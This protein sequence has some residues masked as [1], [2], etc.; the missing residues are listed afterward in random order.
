MREI[1]TAP[2]LLSDLYAGY[3]WIRVKKYKMDE[4]KSWEER[5][6]QLEQHHIEE[7]QFLINKVR[8]LANYCD[9]HMDAA[10]RRIAHNDIT[11]KLQQVV[12]HFSHSDLDSLT[13][14]KN[15]EDEVDE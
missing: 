3:G 5:Y 15:E 4:N 9:G 8:E 6:E 7:T 14:N 2:Y 11:E 1:P 12:K 13:Y 10:T